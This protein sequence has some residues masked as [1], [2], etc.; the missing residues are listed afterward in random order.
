MVGEPDH[1]REI[2][3][4]LQDVYRDLAVAPL[5][6]SVKAALGM[7]GLDVGTPRLPYV[8]LDESELETVR[9]MLERHGMLQPARA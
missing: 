4:R 3:E 5:A 7:I 2:D 9:A 6:C 8:E 1:R